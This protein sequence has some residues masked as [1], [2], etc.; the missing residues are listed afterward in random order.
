MVEARWSSTDPTDEAVRDVLRDSPPRSLR[1][2]WLARDGVLPHH[3]LPPRRLSSGQ[4]L[5][6]ELT[7][8]IATDAKPARLEQG[9]ERADVRDTA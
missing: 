5:G 7:G 2:E 9:A 6:R 4:N 8:I 1:V 3:T